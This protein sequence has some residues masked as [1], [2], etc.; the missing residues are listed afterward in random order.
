MYFNDMS[1]KQQAEEELF[2]KELTCAGWDAKTV[3][4]LL[5]SNMYVY[6]EG[7][8]SIELISTELVLEYY[9]EESVIILII[10]SLKSKEFIRLKLYYGDNLDKVLRFIANC[11]EKLNLKSFPKLLKQIYKFCDRILLAKDDGTF[12]LIEL[13]EK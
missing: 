5:H 6:P 13:P 11:Q 7:N 9:A 8:A 2:V 10:V 12:Y 4:K 3:S 1:E